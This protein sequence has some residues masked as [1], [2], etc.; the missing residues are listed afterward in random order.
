MPQA[1]QIVS[2]TEET[3]D[4]LLLV[5]A[6]KDPALAMMMSLY[7]CFIIRISG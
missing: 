1:V 5:V 4:V 6:N 2:Q 3:H 7:A